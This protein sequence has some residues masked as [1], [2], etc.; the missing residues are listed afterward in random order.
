MNS[1]IVVLSRCRSRWRHWIWFLLLTLLA[2][3]SHAQ[4]VGDYRSLAGGVANFANRSS[5]Q[6]WDG[7]NWVINTTALN[8]SKT[9]TVMH[10][11]TIAATGI[12]ATIGRI[13]VAEDPATG[14]AGT[15]NVNGEV[16]CTAL[17]VDGN[18]TQVT[19]K[20]DDAEFG[21]T[22]ITSKGQLTLLSDARLGTVTV[23]TDAR[24]QLLT[25]VSSATIV[26]PSTVSS[27]GIL[28]V[29]ANGPTLQELTVAAGGQALIGAQ[30]K[31]VKTV[32][33]AGGVLVQQPSGQIQVVRDASASG[34]DFVMNGQLRNESNTAS[35][36]LT[37][38]A[39]AR[40]QA[41]SV[42]TH[43][44]NG[45][46]LPVC[47]WD[48]ASTLEIKGVID[49][50]GFANDNQTFGNLVWDT[51]D[52]GTSGTGSNVFYLN[53][54]G[55]MRLAGKLTVRNTGLGRLQLTPASG[56][57]SIV[58]ELG[59]FE[60]QGG[61]VCVARFG[62]TL[63]RTVKVNGDFVL[64][65]GRFE[66]SNSSSSGEGVLN[67]DGKLRLDGG[68]LLLSGGT[69]AG[70]L[71]LKGDLALNTGSDL[72]REVTGGTATVNFA[73][74][75]VQYFS[76]AS[77]TTITGVVNFAVLSGAALDVGNQVID[78]DGDFVLNAGATL[79]IGHNQGIAAKTPVATAST[80]NVQVKGGRSF[81][82][83]AAYIYNGSATQQTGNGLPANL[84]AGATLGLDNSSG[85]VTLSRATSLA[86]RL[87]LRRG[88]L[89][90]TTNALTL[91]P[92][93]TWAEASDA[94]YVDGP[95]LR[96]TSSAAQVYT[97]PI[98]SGGRLK[99][100]GLR[101]GAATA[102]TYRMM[103]Y[104]ATAPTPDALAPGSGLYNVSRREYWEV[105]RTVGTTDATVRLYYTVPH[106]GVQETLEGRQALRV[107]ALLG[108]QWQN[109]GQA[110][111]PNT[112]E[113]YVDAGQPLTLTT[114]APV[115]VTLGSA[116]PINPLP[117]TLVLFRAKLV[118]KDV[119][120]TW[121]TAQEINC[122]GYE[123]QASG[124]GTNYEI[125]DYYN[126]QG[127]STVAIDYAH[128]DAGAFR[129]GQ[130]VRY[131]RL[132]QLDVDGKFFYSP[133]VA[134]A[135]PGSPAGELVV[136]PVPATDWLNINLNTKQQNELTI[137]VTDALGRLCRVQH[138][139]AA[140]APDVVR[141]PVD[142]LHRGLY[143]VQVETKQSRVQ[144]RFQKE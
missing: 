67:V 80:G 92:A 60:Q 47:T 43:S 82:T 75:Q 48:A 87:L 37:T 14:G 27:G 112:T 79:L 1:T 40:M 49:A 142:Q 10:S 55:S 2:G 58:T 99:V 23:D 118:G 133:V 63:T 104:A 72:R 64:G 141:L 16:H 144:V 66:L 3:S 143:F 94:S 130:R 18:N 35:M 135:A 121:R 90:T 97:F 115:E 109:Y 127:N 12:A 120:V 140:E 77:G 83:A 25:G 84:A 44:A 98:G 45:G 11:K 30:V 26:G 42:Y 107:A 15:L 106:S 126:G 122:A 36:S 46:L 131:Y 85:V 57:G 28:S 76:R 89:Q 21:S 124:D 29:A 137:R 101:P 138:Y 114:G 34:V 111:L 70:T 22:H 52:Y 73:G 93:A 108:G 74:T 5:W 91:A 6:R 61:Q 17:E 8:Y 100:G 68:T 62:S 54:A 31:L 33:D 69:A 56:S 59:E 32:V 24:L 128:L 38:G 41:G 113:K 134:V 78:G 71:N 105:A 136:W 125:L 96:Q 13:V 9:F 102:A 123:V 7:S 88:R 95:L 86:G 65:S 19:I 81:S 119:Q 51:P 117:I 116:T 4:A 129:N 103:A 53:A 20:S 132:R 110:A 50:S 139:P 39:Q